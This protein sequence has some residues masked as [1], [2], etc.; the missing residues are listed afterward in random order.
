MCS[1]DP[2]VLASDAM[3]HAAGESAAIIPAVTREEAPHLPTAI[4]TPAMAPPP[5]D[6]PV[7]RP[8]RTDVASPT[9][10]KRD[11]VNTS[12]TS[13]W[14]VMS[15]RGHCQRRNGSWQMRGLLSCYNQ[16]PQLVA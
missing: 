10:L 11:Y 13:R 9:M 14:F 12:R 6:E 8:R 7:A 3:V 5:H 16:G 2:L 1:V 15:G 4:S